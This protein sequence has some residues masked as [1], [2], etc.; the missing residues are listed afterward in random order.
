MVLKPL[1]SILRL[2]SITRCPLSLA[3]DVPIPSDVPSMKKAL[4]AW[5]WFNKVGNREVR[6]FTNCLLVAPL[7]DVLFLVDVYERKDF[8]FISPNI[9]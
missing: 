4:F 1:L 6:V 9:L 5:T 3:Y 7:A 2:T 8:V